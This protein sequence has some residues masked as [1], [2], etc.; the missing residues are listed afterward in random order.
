MKTYAT[1]LVTPKELHTSVSRIIAIILAGILND[2]FVTK[3]CT[4]IKAALTEL[5]N[6][7][8]R[9][10]DPE[11]INLL[12]AKD[13]VR[14]SRYVT[15]RDYCKALSG[16]EDESLAAAG[17]SLIVIL[18]ELGWG[19]H[20]KGYADETALLNALFDKLS[21]APASTAVTTIGATARFTSL[22]TAQVDFE[23]TYDAKVDQ[24]AKEEYPK[25][26]ECQLEIAH[27][28]NGLLGYIGLVAEMDGGSYHTTAEK[29]DEVITEFETIARTRHTRKKSDKKDDDTGTTSK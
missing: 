20:R 28:L 7:L 12:A 29:I 27:Y 8:G 18:K 1:S 9:V 5:S 13:Q 11:V 24:K 4:R 22:K 23:T 16:D 6:V 15:F 26:R 19:M 10:N 2:A 25:M 17:K 21:V 3:V 14:D